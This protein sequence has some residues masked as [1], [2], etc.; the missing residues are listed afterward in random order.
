M[1]VGFLF[2][3]ILT[4]LLGGLELVLGAFILL[5]SFGTPSNNPTGVP[6][7]LDYAVGAALVVVPLALIVTAMRTR[8]SV[9]AWLC[10]GAV[11]AIFF[12]SL[13][14]LFL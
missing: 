12:F 2:P 11:A 13:T 14:T 5:T 9:V 8:S 3:R 10:A 6:G 1:S 7:A 4:V